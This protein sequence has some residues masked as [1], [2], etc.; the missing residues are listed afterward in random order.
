MSDSPTPY[1][2][3]PWPDRTGN[4]DSMALKMILLLVILPIAFL[5][6]LVI[7]PDLALWVGGLALLAV[8]ARIFWWFLTL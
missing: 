1:R 6:L 7:A 2:H 4:A 5:V 8:G 3:E